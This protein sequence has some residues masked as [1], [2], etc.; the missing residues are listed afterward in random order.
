LAATGNPT[1][2]VTAPH[3]LSLAIAAT[4][5]ATA[6]GCAPAA[7]AHRS[8][9]APQPVLTGPSAEPSLAQRRVVD[10]GGAGAANGASM[11]RC[12]DCVRTHLTAD[13][14][15]HV[16]TRIAA[17]KL[18]G[19]P[20]ATYAEVL[21]RSIRDGRVTIR[22][23]MWRVGH[24]LVSGEAYPDGAIFLAR[25]IDPLN[26][27]RRTL[28]DVVWTLEHEAA[29]IALKLDAPFDRAPGDRADAIVREC[30]S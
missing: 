13:E 14:S 19:A 21:E 4:L 11:E 26:V 9:P 6:A 30:R 29:H 1:T 24:Q 27:G 20:C 22:P 5:A 25:E 10:E 3:R 16:Q 15:L 18:R 2:P 28:E 23:Y 17:L 8:S 7:G 12:A